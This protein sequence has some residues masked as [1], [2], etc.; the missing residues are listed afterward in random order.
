MLK[1][2]FAVEVSIIFVKNIKKAS[3]SMFTLLVSQIYELPK[4]YLHFYKT[5]TYKGHKWSGVMF[6]LMSYSGN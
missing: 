1:L 6:I 4:I 3:S 2:E 5:N